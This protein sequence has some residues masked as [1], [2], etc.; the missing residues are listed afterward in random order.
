MSDRTWNSV[1][2]RLYE[3]DWSQGAIILC[4]CL[5]AR[6]PNQYGLFDMPWG[7]LKLFFKGLYTRSEIESYVT[8]WEATGFAK[9]YRDRQVIW[10]VKK[11]KRSGN[12]GELH[13]KGLENLLK[14][15]PEVREG[16][17]AYYK[18]LYKGIQTPLNGDKQKP[19]PLCNSE[20][21]SD[22]ELLIKDMPSKSDGVS[23]PSDKTGKLKRKYIPIEE[24]NAKTPTTR[25]IRSWHRL[26]KQVHNAGYV[27]DIRKM[28]GQ[29]K[30]ALRKNDE[31]VIKD[32]MEYLFA[33]KQDDYI[34][35]DFDHFIRKLSHYIIEKDRPE[36]QK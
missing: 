13:W 4:A 10:I 22:S 31:A 16:F 30:L 9:L 34:R 25:L 36:K 29:M 24:R 26:F 14:D 6:C 5:L 28:G 35:H 17:M 32:T 7:F 27:G 8:E 3:E 11:W 21:E 33:L 15:F 23:Q 2:A 20:S 1:D 12:P 18:P 19:E